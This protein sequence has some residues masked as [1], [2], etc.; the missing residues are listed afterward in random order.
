MRKILTFTERD[1]SFATSNIGSINDVSNH[2][3]SIQP[4]DNSSVFNDEE[5]DN[6]DSILS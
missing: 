6:F 2:N 4:D 1:S 5:N 3:N